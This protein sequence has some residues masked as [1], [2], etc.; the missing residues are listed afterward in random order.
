M[1]NFQV[2]QRHISLNFKTLVVHNANSAPKCSNPQSSHSSTPFEPTLPKTSFFILITRS[3]QPQGTYTV[4]AERVIVPET[5]NPPDTRNRIKYARNT[6]PVEINNAKRGI[7]RTADSNRAQRLT[8][9]FQ[10]GK[11]IRIALTEVCVHILAHT[12]TTSLAGDQKCL[13]FLH[14]EFTRDEFASSFLNSIG[15][16]SFHVL[17]RC[18]CTAKG[19]DNHLLGQQFRSYL[20]SCTRTSVRSCTLLA[21]AEESRKSSGIFYE[22]F[23]SPQ[24]KQMMKSLGS[25]SAGY[26]SRKE[27]WGQLSKY[28]VLWK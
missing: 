11:F 2:T 5:D 19:K 6:G 3:K 9:S 1:C 10:R 17:D 25:F 22:G 4:T 12:R 20:N 27:Y 15:H 26:I 23:F 13:G 21:L 16:A 18:A 28:L 8:Q 24:T 7:V 14:T